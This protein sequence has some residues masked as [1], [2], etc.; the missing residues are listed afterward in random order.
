MYI[1]LPRL[2]TAGVIILIALIAL[3]YQS[4]GSLLGYN[5]YEE[6]VLREAQKSENPVM[7]AIG[8]YCQKH[9]A[10]EQTQ[11]WQSDPVFDPNKPFTEVEPSSS[12]SGVGFLNSN[13]LKAD[14]I[15]VLLFIGFLFWAAIYETSKRKTKG[16]TKTV[17]SSVEEGATPKTSTRGKK[18]A[19]N[20]RFY[21]ISKNDIKWSIPK[22]VLL[23]LFMI[24]SVLLSAIISELLMLGLA[25][26]SQLA[27]AIFVPIALG[28]LYNYKINTR[29]IASLLGSLVGVIA[30]IICVNLVQPNSSP[31][32]GAIVALPFIFSALTTNY[33]CHRPESV[34]DH[35]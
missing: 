35:N 15:G 24:F 5:T 30:W 31:I 11:P 29:V 20:V 9:M 2:V 16:S 28:I 22:M 25:F 19:E 10:E 3:I 13:R 14:D 17:T 12:S 6:C 4:N 7:Q 33:I 8:R 23:I 27:I 26:Q 18:T 34:G 1:S 32:M 21:I